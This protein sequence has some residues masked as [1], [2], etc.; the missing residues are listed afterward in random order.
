MMVNGKPTV[1]YIGATSCVWCGSNRW[2]MA[3]ALSRFG[4]FGRL[5]KGYSALQDSDVPTLFWSADNITTQSGINFDNNYTSNYISFIS[6]E[7]ES[8]ITKGFEMAPISYFIQNAPN[9]TYRQAMTFMNNTGEVRRH[10]LHP[11]G[12]HH[13][14]RCRRGRL[15]QFH[16]DRIIPAA[17]G[18]DSPAGSRPVQQVQ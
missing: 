18:H 1:I 4:T 5:Y 8:P 17:Y 12:Q 11:L 14:H 2:A 3:L 7:F 15:R 10:A 9:P 6:A 13:T 16:P